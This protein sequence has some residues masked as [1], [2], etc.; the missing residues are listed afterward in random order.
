MAAKYED[1]AKETKYQESVDGAQRGYLSEGYKWRWERMI[2]RD[3]HD[4]SRRRSD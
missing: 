1:F 2:N 3:M 4:K